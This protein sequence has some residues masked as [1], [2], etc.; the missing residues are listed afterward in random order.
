MLDEDLSKGTGCPR[1]FENLFKT[2]L[3]PRFG[4][5]KTFRQCVDIK[6][7]IREWK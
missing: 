4:N 7:R 3:R 5:F 2:F 6:V 1:F